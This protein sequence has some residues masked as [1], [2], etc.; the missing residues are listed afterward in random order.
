MFGT[1]GLVFEKESLQIRKAV[2]R[3]GETG[4]DRAS[5]LFSLRCVN[6]HDGL[7]KYLHSLYVGQR[8][9]NRAGDMNRM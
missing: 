2:R 6:P 5:V 9:R 1:V 7:F 4:D 8:W 3:K